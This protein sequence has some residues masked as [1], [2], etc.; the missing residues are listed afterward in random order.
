MLRCSWSRSYHHVISHVII[1]WPLCDYSIADVNECALESGGCQHKCVNRAGSYRCEC[2]TGYILQ[3]DGKSCR[4]K[5]EWVCLTYGAQCGHLGRG[6]WANNC[7]GTLTHT[8]TQLIHAITTTVGVPT[9]VPATQT[10]I[11]SA[12]AELDTD[13]TAMEKPAAVSPQT[14]YSYTAVLTVYMPL[15]K[16]LDLCPHP[17]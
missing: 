3:A 7:T 15:Y 14:N 4:T 11:F 6:L 17:I 10:E 5:S 12:A 2:N 8:H 1:M 9:F 16:Y 13:W